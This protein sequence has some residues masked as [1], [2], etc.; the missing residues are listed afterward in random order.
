MR[1]GFGIIPGRVL[2][3]VFPSERFQKEIMHISDSWLEDEVR[4]G[5][6]VPALMKQCWAAQM[7]LLSDL[8]EVCERHGLRWYAAFGTLLGAARHGGYVPWDDDI[9]IWMPRRD[10]EMFLRFGRKE[11]PEGCRIN[12]PSTRGGDSLAPPNIANGSHL[13]LDRARLSKYHGFPY[14]V[15]I[16]IFTMDFS[17]RDPERE[18]ARRMLMLAVWKMH[19]ELQ[20]GEKDEK[21]LLRE[22]RE[23][24]RRTG[25]RPSGKTIMDKIFSAFQ[26]LCTLFHEEE[27]DRMSYLP[28]TYIRG[29]PD[30]PL[31]AFSEMLTLPFENGTIRVPS[32]YQELL[33]VIY[34]N[35]ETPARDGSLH[36]YPC[37]R[38]MEAEIMDSL[39]D[40]ALFRYVFSPSD[41]ENPARAAWKRPLERAGEWFSDLRRSGLLLHDG[42]QAGEY[43]LVLRLL[44][45]S[46]ELALRIGT[47]LEESGCIGAGDAVA[48]LEEYCEALFRLHQDVRAYA[49]Q[50]PNI[51]LQKKTFPKTAEE[52]TRTLSELLERMGECFRDGLSERKEIV[53]LPWKASCWKNMEEAYF[54][55]KEHDDFDVFVIPLPWHYREADGSLRQEIICEREGFPENVKITDYR[56]YN[57]AA[58]HPAAIIIQN[59]YDEYNTVTSVEPSY[60][61]SL[62]KAYTDRLVYIPWFTMDEVD[63][64]KPSDSFAV[65]N[66]RY[67]VTVPGVVHADM[68]L[69]DSEKTRESYV[70]VL[71]SLS[72]EDFREVWER[73]LV[74]DLDMEKW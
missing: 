29:M 22:L 8:N 4:C 39:K 64:R 43:G 24:E 14:P 50:S 17:S 47:M 54:K 12:E 1:D 16:D 56:E 65:Y 49:E 42:L 48:L 46:Q 72:G 23:V 25:V 37:Y 9:D 7:E 67:Y 10:Y 15:S 73:K 33:R 20:K 45:S 40:D 61:S 5:F 31:T 11:L 70:H 68:V 28:N 44:E 52:G 59:P 21:Q 62:L 27:S 41:M 2:R 26:G 63:Y 66:M 57:F 74:F 38:E 36:A 34:G 71:T 51:D 53:F 35:Y 6:Y 58:R 3:E 69:L 19:F 18:K 55:A 30:Y 13:I 32:G 60:Y